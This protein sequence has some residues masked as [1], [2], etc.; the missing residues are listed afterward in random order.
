MSKV[1]AHRGASGY[2]PENTM[3]AFELALEQDAD[4]IELDVHLTRD[5]EVVVIHDE[6]LER[7]TDGHGWVADHSLDQLKK[8]DAGAGM[9]GFAGARIPTLREVLAL[10]QPTGKTVNIELKNDAMKYKGLEERVLAL[11]DEFGMHDRI[12]ISTFN[13]YSLRN[14]REMGAPVPLGAL[15]TDPLFKPWKYVH[16]LGV[17]LIHPPARAVR[18]H[19]LVEKSHE[20]GL[21]VNVW[22]VNTPKEI[23]RMGK[24]GVDAVITNYPNMARSI[25]G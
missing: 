21:K 5:D 14:L 7:T 3:P 6:T 23:K 1:W 2:A 4:G 10:M 16:K 25:L 9:E 24:L 22:T 18:E 17:E 13:H 12:V 19:K 15:F 11:I 20:L 8:L